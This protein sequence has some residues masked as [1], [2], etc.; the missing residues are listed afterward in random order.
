MPIVIDHDTQLPVDDRPAPI[1]L[2]IR[3]ID[4]SHVRAYYE[5]ARALFS[6]AEGMGSGEELGLPISELHAIRSERD[7]RHAQYRA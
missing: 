3:P 5:Q 2:L 6:N 4:T 1:R 7:R